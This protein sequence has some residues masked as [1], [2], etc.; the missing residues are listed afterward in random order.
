VIASSRTGIPKM[1]PDIFP[2]AKIV[3]WVPVA[4]VLK[5]KVKLAVE[6]MMARFQDNPDGLLSFAEVQAAVCMPDAGNFRRRIRQHT[7]FVA[8]CE[9]LGVEEWG[10]RAYLKCFRRKP[11]DP[12]TTASS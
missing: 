10:P 1:L 2:G 8:A 7:D 6:Y 4:K 3:D 9:K 12:A 5:G 11:C